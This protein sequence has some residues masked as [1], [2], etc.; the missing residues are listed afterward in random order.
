MHF[1][2]PGGKRGRRWKSWQLCPPPAQSAEGSPR[3]PHRCPHAGLPSPPPAWSPGWTAHNIWLDPLP[4]TIK[5]PER[6]G[7]AAWSHHP[8]GVRAETSPL[9]HLRAGSLTD[10]ASAK[11]NIIWK[12]MELGLSCHFQLRVPL[13]GGFFRWLTGVIWQNPDSGFT[14]FT[15]HPAASSLLL[16]GKHHKTTQCPCMP[17]TRSEEL[18]LCRLHNGLPR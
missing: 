18:T 7:M 12:I 8:R 10:A 13:L 1:S 14:V 15:L 5:C 16:S 17:Q 11:A 6:N 2:L 3:R 4:P 9:G